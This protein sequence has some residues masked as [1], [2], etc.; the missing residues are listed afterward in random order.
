[1]KDIQN[2]GFYNF[3]AYRLDVKNRL[4]FCGEKPV[5]MTLKEFEVLLFLVENA[6]QVIEKEDL[7]DAVWKDIFIEEG[8][9]TRNISRLRKKL[10]TGGE[11]F[12]ETLPKRGYRFLPPVTKSAGNALVIEEQILS[13]IR[14][15]ETLSLPELNATAGNFTSTL[16]LPDSGAPTRSNRPIFWL[17]I[18]FGFAACAAIGIILYQNYFQQREPKAIMASRVVPFSGLPGR[19]SFPAFSPDGRQIAFAWDGGDGENQ[20]I[21]V[22]LVGAGEPLR[23]TKSEMNSINPVFSPDGRRIAFSR[24]SAETTEIFTVSALG[25]AERR[26]CAVHSGGSSFSWSPD[27]KT[28]AVPDTDQ[29]NPSTGIFFVAVET[30]EKRRL[31]SAPENLTDNTPRFSPDGKRVAFLRNAGINEMDLYIISVADGGQQARRVTF[32]SA[33]INGLTWSADGERIIFASMRGASSSSNL[34]QI[35]AT[36]GEPEPLLTGGKNPANPAVA[37][38]GKLIAFVEES[39]DTNIWRIE[40]TSSSEK[41]F[42]SRKFIASTRADH[43]PNISPDGGKIAFVTDRTGTEEIWTTNTDGSN[44]QQIAAH[45]GSPRF[46]P[47]GKFVAYDAQTSGNSDVFVVSAEGGATRRLT[48]DASQEF[49]PAWSADGQWVYFCSDRSGSN[50]LWKIHVSGKGEARQI[51]QNGAFEAFATP[52]GRK[53]FYTKENGVAGL[54]SVPTESGEEMPVAELTEAGYWR[55]WTVTQNGICYVALSSSPPY[56]INFYDFSDGQTREL[57]ATEKTPL[58]NFSGLSASADGKT[59]FYAQ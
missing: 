18:V 1:V 7:L 37:P 56:Q 12:I 44:Q 42:N 36:G 41:Q 39:N 27:G 4:L 38:D 13:H 48:F 46:S 30:G 25:G 53:I 6:G 9:L 32:D 59:I 23:L 24:S 33:K 19:E 15:E 2:A 14:V 8:T 47:D 16:A 45:G 20:D 21:Y 51:T 50:Q 43:S 17:A 52:D 3:G 57:A 49:L 55:S 31:T 10:G 28:L 35:A 29:T 11:N 40:E 54:W 5:A 58:W 22:R 26:I 34:W